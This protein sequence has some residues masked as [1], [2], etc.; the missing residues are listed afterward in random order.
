MKHTIGKFLLII[1]SLIVAGIL[2]EIAIRIFRVP[3]PAIIQGAYDFPCYTKTNDNW[4]ALKPNARCRIHS[5]ENA[6]PDISVQTNS[7]GLRNPELVLPKPPDQ[8]RIVFIGD[9]FTFGFGVAENEAFPRLVGNILQS[10]LPA[11]TIEAVNAGMPGVGTGRYWVRYNGQNYAKDADIVVVSL[12][13]FNDIHDEEFKPENVDTNGDGFPDITHSSTAHVDSLGNIVANETPFYLETPILRDSKMLKLMTAWYLSTPFASARFK[14]PL[15]PVELCLYKPTCH[16]FDADIEQ[17]K[18]ILLAMAKTSR[19]RNQ[20]LLFVL[21]PAEFQIYDLARYK[22]FIP[23]P[24]SPEEKRRPN[25]LFGA[26]FRENNIDY[27]DL[28]PGFE[29]H[30]DSR[31]YLVHDIHWNEAGHEL[32]AQVVTDKLLTYFKP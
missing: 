19:D 11:R 9:S 31:L 4:I 15:I 5:N 26:F 7:L 10:Q 27:L 16:S 24:L 32:A 1:I 20:K 23:I 30:K 21:I 17:K 28:L 29:T 3:V 25:E 2:A 22:F 6:F 18:K 14:K 13:L 12:Y 8:T